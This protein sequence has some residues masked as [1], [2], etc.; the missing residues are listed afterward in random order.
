[1]A[2][3]ATTANAVISII[4]AAFR[5][6]GRIDKIRAEEAAVRSDLALPSKPVF[7]PPAKVAMIRELQQLLDQTPDSAPEP[8]VRRLQDLKTALAGSPD[9]RTLLGF[10]EELLPEKVV[11]K[12]DDPSAELLKNLKKRSAALGLTEDEIVRVAFYLNAGEDL[13]AASLPWQIAM[14]VVDT[15]ADVA[16]ANQALLLRN[17]RAR[18]ILSAVLQRFAD[19]DLSAI[20]SSR[21]L[22]R[23]VLRTTVNGTIDAADDLTGDKAWVKSLLSAL[24][25]TR[26]TAG[27]D[28]IIDLVDGRGYPALVGNLLEEGAGLLT[29]TGAGHFEHIAADVLIRA[30]DLA[31]DRS[32]FRSFF[33]DHWGDLL[34][35]GLRSVHTHGDNILEG[36]SPLLQATLLSAIDTLADAGNKELLSSAV[37]E[38][39][40]EAAI[41]AIALKPALL[42]EVTDEP[43]LKKL[44]EST[45]I[46]LASDLDRAFTRKGVNALV[47]TVMINL[48]EEPELLV[49]DSE[50]L[51]TVVGS[52]LRSLANSQKPRLDVIAAATASAVLDKIVETPEL[53]DIPYPAAVAR[54]AAKISV[55][56]D[57]AKLTR[58]EV[59]DILLSVAEVLA[60]NPA[61]VLDQDDSLAADVLSGALEA[62][63]DHRDGPITSKT[64][65]QV[66]A[67]VLDVLSAHS[68]FLGQRKDLVGRSIKSFMDQLV[69]QKPDLRIGMLANAGLVAFLEAAT[70]DPQLLGTRYSESIGRAARQLAEALADGTINSAEAVELVHLTAEI[71][72]H[73]A[74]VLI[75]RHSPLA[76]LLVNSILE[77]IV[78]EGGLR[79]G[80]MFEVYTGVLEILSGRT[81]LLLGLDP[82]ERLAERVKIVLKAG[83]EKSKRELG[84]TIGADVIPAILVGLLQ[85]WADDRLPTLDLDDSRF[86]ERFDE[87]I[88]QIV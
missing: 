71:V 83:L 12:V 88:N 76:G 56:I 54:V 42:D 20:G 52:L 78:T 38:S 21:I 36:Q 79:G 29:G 1:M 66:S 87:L 39:T 2:I 80:A 37:L 74:I 25:K 86:L 6:S 48:A 84:R 7:I 85:I 77:T 9:E 18:P 41:G 27:D 63:L 59:K 10:M 55:S 58:K 51:Q 13:R 73:N 3:P 61:I 81:D 30:A 31:E 53:I 82:L 45:T 33:N 11:F 65:H 26:E 44:L 47:R 50:I 64:I 23:T 34:R 46:V 35:A 49:R 17:D 68:A 70:E 24:S 69:A 60:E 15:L 14:T 57:D 75:D 40:L 43:W 16:V 62:L 4:N 22:L 67:A 19:A 8:E 5:L 28:F 32:D 72:A